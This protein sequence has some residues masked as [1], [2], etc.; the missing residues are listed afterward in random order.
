MTTS[1]FQLGLI[2][3]LSIGLG[4]ALSSSPAIG[5]PSGPVVSRGSSPIVNAGGRLSDPGWVSVMT[6]PSEYDL[7]VTDIVF[8][9]DNSGAGNPDLRLSSGESV[10]QFYVYG[11]SYNGGGVVHLDLKTG[12]RIAAGQSLELNSNTTNNIAYAFSGYLAQP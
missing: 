9:S 12:I 3:T 4:M 10:G 5:Y 11:G 6:A 2:C 1:H 8:S 7:V